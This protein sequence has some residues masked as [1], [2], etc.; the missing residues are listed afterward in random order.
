MLTLLRRLTPTEEI[1][2]V[3]LLDHFHN[4][5]DYRGLIYLPPRVPVIIV[6]I[7]S[8]LQSLLIQF[9]TRHIYRF[10]SSMVED[11]IISLFTAREVG[12]HDNM[13]IHALFTAI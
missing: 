11:N 1:R 8:V 9:R 13:Q 3:E 4:L 12:L 6:I 5:F 7:D 10:A 2:L